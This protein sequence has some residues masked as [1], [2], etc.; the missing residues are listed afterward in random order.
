MMCLSPPG[1]LHQGRDSR[2]FRVRGHARFKEQIDDGFIALDDGLKKAFFRILDSQ[3]IQFFGCPFL[4]IGEF[5]IHLRNN[6]IH[7][8]IVMS[9]KNILFSCQGFIGGFK[10]STGRG[11]DSGT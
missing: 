3:V 5:C 4:F 2:L 1:R 8:N 6:L 10:L 11:R 9:L 7:I